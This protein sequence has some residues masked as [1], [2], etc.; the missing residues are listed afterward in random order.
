MY[1][2][3]PTAVGLGCRRLVRTRLQLHYQLVGLLLAAG[4]DG[5][6]VGF[7]ARTLYPPDSLSYRRAHSATLRLIESAT[8]ALPIWQ[9]TRDERSGRGV[10][11]VGLDRAQW[12]AWMAG[13][14][15]MGDDADGIH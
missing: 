2:A 1:A 3:M 9:T 11:Y 7:V 14:Y 6:P 8:T 15:G 12:A 13:E 5:L 4:P 10:V